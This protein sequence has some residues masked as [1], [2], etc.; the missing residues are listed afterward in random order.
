M[1]HFDYNTGV[2]DSYEV[3]EN[4]HVYAA[5][6]VTPA[7]GDTRE[8]IRAYLAENE[9]KMGRGWRRWYETDYDDELGLTIEI[10]FDLRCYIDYYDDEDDEDNAE[11]QRKECAIEGICEMM[12]VLAPNRYELCDDEF[13][14]H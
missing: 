13:E 8:T 3:A 12:D 14:I 6:L 7:A 9:K 11:E 5:V 1:A 4:C 10:E 2:W